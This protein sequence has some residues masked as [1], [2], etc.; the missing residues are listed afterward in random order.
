MEEEMRYARILVLGILSFLIFCPESGSTHEKK[1]L[2]VSVKPQRHWKKRL[3]IKFSKETPFYIKKAFFIRLGLTPVAYGIFG[4][5][6]AEWNG[7]SPDILRAELKKEFENFKKAAKNVP[8]KAY[9]ESYQVEDRH[10]RVVPKGGCVKKLE[11][12]RANKL[13]VPWYDEILGISKARKFI[14][15][16][17]IPLHPQGVVIVDDGPSLK[18]PDIAPAL[19]RDISG[20][21]VFWARNRQRP[22]SGDH[23][24]H[25]ACLAAGFHD[26]N[27]IDGIAAPNAYL[28]PIII[29]YDDDDFFFASDIAIGLK[30]FADLEEEGNI[31]FRVINMSFSMSYELQILKAAIMALPQKLFVSAAS[32]E[33]DDLDKK[34]RYPASWRFANTMAVAA[35]DK[36]DRLAPFSNYGTRTVDIAAPGTNILSC[37]SNGGYEPYRGTSMSTPIVAGAAALILAIKPG[38]TVEH[39]KSILF[40]SATAKESLK[41]KIKGGRRLNV[42]GAVEQLWTLM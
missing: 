22:G 25:V 1:P 17:K 11:N 3:L 14:S 19:I 41:N 2:K 39:L 23:G 10:R 13:I 6:I 9:V 32:N 8:A 36:E 4:Y 29:N 21:P 20:Q 28:L 34:K 31:R 33:M 12:I 30:Y 40:L 16:K 5:D 26:G 27:G 42:Y 38:M 37:V 35:T 24:T 15:E 7:K 18:H